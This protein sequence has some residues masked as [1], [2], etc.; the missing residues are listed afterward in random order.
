MANASH[1]HEARWCEPL[2]LEKGTVGERGIRVPEAEKLVL[3]T[4]G[5]AKFLIPE[6]LRR[7]E[8]PRLPEL[9]QMQVLRHYL[10][11]SQETVGTDVTID[12]GLGT[13][14]MKYSPKVHE[15]LVRN[16]G[17]SQVH[18]Y[19]D[20]S[21]IQGLLRIFYETGEYLQEISG[22]DQFTLQ[23]SSGTQAIY[24]AVAIMKAYHRDNNPGEERDEIIT[25]M[26]SH[27]GNPGAAATA[28]YKVVTLNPGADGLPDMEHLRSA[29]SERT[30]GV[31]ITNPEDTGIFNPRID[32]LVKL[33]HE[34]GG[35][36]FYDQANQNGLFGITR[37]K[38]AGFDMCHFNLHKTFSSPHGSHGPGAGALGVRSFLAP[39]LPVPVVM[40]NGER[41]Y[42]DYDRPASIGKLRKF[43][44][45]APVIVRAYAYIRSMGAE[46]LNLVSQI[47]ILNNNY[48]LKK[49][50]DI[51][52]LSLPWAEGVRRLEQARLSWE[53]LTKATG[54]TTDDI[55]RRVVDYGFQTYFT[56]HHPRL[57][58]EPLTPE[59][60]ETY[61]RDD[62]DRF[63]E[64]LAAI[65]QEAYQ[66][67]ETVKNAPHKSALPYRADTSYLTDIRKFA[68]TWRAFLKKQSEGVNEV[69]A[70]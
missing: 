48:M 25:T 59:P 14:T 11:L 60:V 15:T 68:C 12:I 58:P 54:V 51:P 27:P 70:D 19:Q 6:N 39:Y 29:V 62:I 61:S 13:C 1:F 44:G 45:V 43:F 36:C 47:A 21:T 46:G 69:G 28:G 33:V 2:I 66:E 56:S 63:V 42:L 65:A 22:M 57:I 4:V 26:L 23:P 49:M 67:P 10:H 52:G 40:K 55:N 16:E 30:A 34:V 17:V 5:Q 3:D 31:L 37:A 9:S 24:A 50:E 35:L 41:Y 32:E 8:A 64:A 53:E 20:E 18:P 38:E 7:I